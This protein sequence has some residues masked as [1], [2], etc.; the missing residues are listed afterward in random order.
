MVDGDGATGHGFSRRRVLANEHTTGYLT[1]AA[2]PAIGHRSSA[3]D[4]G[5]RRPTVEH[6]AV[7][8]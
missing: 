4:D 2:P 6:G 5:E 1:E 8:I 7:T 3:G